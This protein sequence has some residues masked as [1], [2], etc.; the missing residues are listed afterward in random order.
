MSCYQWIW[1]GLWGTV[2]ALVIAA[3]LINWSPEVVLG[4]ARGNERDG[5]FA[6][7]AGAVEQHDA[8]LAG[9]GGSLHG[10]QSSG[11]GRADA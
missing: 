6:K 8:V 5:P 4:I 11:S 10:Y 9:L 3:A 7:G 1:R 2:A